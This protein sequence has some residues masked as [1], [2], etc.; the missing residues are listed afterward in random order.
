[1]LYKCTKR[2]K[3]QDPRNGNAFSVTDVFI[4]HHDIRIYLPFQNTDT[5][6]ITRENYCLVIVEL[7]LSLQSRW[8]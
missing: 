2:K 6:F 3:T 8:S 5:I 1:M 7:F 4:N